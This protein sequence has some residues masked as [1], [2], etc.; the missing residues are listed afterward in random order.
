MPSKRRL[1]S[2]KPRNRPE[3]AVGR[4]PAIPAPLIYSTPEEVIECGGSGTPPR[5]GTFTP[6]A[7]YTASAPTPSTSG[8][9][10]IIAWRPAECDPSLTRVMVPQGSVITEAV[11]WAALA[12]RI[13]ELVLLEP[14]PEEAAGSACRALGVAGVENPNQ[15]GQSLVE[16]SSELRQ[17]LYFRISYWEDPF[18][19]VAH[20]KLAEVR[21]AIADTDLEFWISLAEPEMRARSLD[22]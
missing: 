7:P 11:W 14:E 16:G 17:N 20:E 1:I 3:F 22:D 6:P 18:P 9:P 13:T 15:A 21:E 2:I 8:Q 19:A 12:D 4:K 10:K 5:I